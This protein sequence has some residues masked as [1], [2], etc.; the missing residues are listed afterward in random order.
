MD[1]H[2]FAVLIKRRIEDNCKFYYQTAEDTD[3]LQ[4][5]EFKNPRICP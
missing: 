1:S 3:K 2:I 5:L 4:I